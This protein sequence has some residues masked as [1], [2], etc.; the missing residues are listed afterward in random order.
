MKKFLILIGLLSLSSCVQES[1]PN[2]Q[3]I[4]T[5][6]QIHGKD[7]EVY[8]IDSCEYIGSIYWTNSDLLT[9]KGDCKFC[10]ERKLNDK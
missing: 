5:I 6:T 3:V 1:S 10:K 8:V 7:I 2:V 9:H 4:P